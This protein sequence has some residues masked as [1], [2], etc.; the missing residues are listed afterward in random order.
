MKITRRNG[1]LMEVR[2]ITVGRVFE[3]EDGHIYQKVN[4][5]I[6]ESGADKIRLNAVAL[7]NGQLTWFDDHEK[8]CLCEAELIIS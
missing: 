3:D 2:N 1:V 6:Y 8:V 5:V 4:Q 7:L